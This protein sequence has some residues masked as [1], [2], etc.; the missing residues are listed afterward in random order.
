MS[1]E[2]AAR[3]PIAVKATDT[4]A[5]TA[6]AGLSV[7]LVISVAGWEPAYANGAVHLAKETA[8]ALVLLMVAALLAGRVARTGTLLD[9][10]ALAGVLVLAIKNLVFSVLTAALAEPTDALTSWRTTGAGMIA[11]ALLAVAALAPRRVVRDRR[12][13][14]LITAVSSLAAFVVVSAITGLLD[15]PGALTDR[16]DTSAELRLLGQHPVLVVADV[17]ASVL[18]LIAGLVFA[19]RAQREADEFHLWLGIGA[20]IAAI[21]YL[22]YALFPSPYTDFLHAGD[23]FRVAAV[24]ALGIGTIREV[25]RYQ[26]LY[27]PAAVFDKRQRMARDLHDGVAQ[28]LAFIESRLHRLRKRDQDDETL[29]EI[30]EA[31]QRAMEASRRSISTLSRPLEEPLNVALTNTAKAAVG[32]AGTRL[33]LDLPIDVVVP[34]A[35]EYPLQD[36]VREAVTNAVQHGRART[37]TVRLQETDRISLRITDDGDGFDPTRQRDGTGFGLIT[38]RERIE[39]LG[40]EF[41]LTSAPGRRTCLEVVL[42]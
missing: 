21:G 41:R 22:N 38:I 35:W 3:R 19:H 17:A 30:A 28:E 5:L 13:A 37:V 26:A 8:T 34:A 10:L 25:S 15:L 1:N 6:A 18:F 32:L 2:S 42:P 11:A 14:I 23:L 40:G 9:L 12:R 31:V 24:L 33:E 4:V 16:P 27:A 20:T 29:A 7:T 36:I 39:S